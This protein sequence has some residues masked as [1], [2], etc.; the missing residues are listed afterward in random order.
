[1]RR[2]DIIRFAFEEFST[3]DTDQWKVDLGSR[4]VNSGYGRGELE[5]MVDFCEQT[6]EVITRV[7]DL[8]PE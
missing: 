1:V 3:S 7:R 6:A 4:L 5:L 8:H 2:A